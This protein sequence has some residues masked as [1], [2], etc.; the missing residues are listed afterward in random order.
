MILDSIACVS[1]SQF[2]AIKMY[3]SGGGAAWLALPFGTHNEEGYKRKSPLS[4]AL[5]KSR[6]KNLVVVDTVTASD[7][8]KKL[9]QRCLN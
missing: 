7:P 1:D 3:L 2:E 9:I 5:L 8:M 6:Y 4:N